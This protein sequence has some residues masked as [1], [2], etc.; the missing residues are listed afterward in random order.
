MQM[1][2]FQRFQKFQSFCPHLDPPGDAGGRIR[3]G[4]NHSNGLNVLDLPFNLDQS[5]NRYSPENFTCSASG[6]G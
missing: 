6:N 3:W 2:A 4:L 1:H 5:R